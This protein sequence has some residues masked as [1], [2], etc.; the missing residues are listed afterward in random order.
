MDPENPYYCV[1]FRGKMYICYKEDVQVEKKNTYTLQLF[2]QEITTDL[3]KS[4]Y[5]D[6]KEY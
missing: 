1:H 6:S 4:R 3:E 5:M 2:L